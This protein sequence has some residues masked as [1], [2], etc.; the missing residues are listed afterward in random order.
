MQPKEVQHQMSGED[1]PMLHLTHFTMYELDP[2]GLMTL[3]MGSQGYRY[4]DRYTVDDIDHT[5]K[6]QQHVSNLTAQFGIYKGTLLTL[7]GNVSY[8]RDDGLAFYSQEARYDKKTTRFVSDTDFIAYKGKDTLRG[9]YIDH[10]DKTGKI[11]ARNIN[12]IYNLQ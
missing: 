8:V 9:T 3:M 2:H 6:S 5:D 10:N 11:H 7:D 4:K 12:A 1:V